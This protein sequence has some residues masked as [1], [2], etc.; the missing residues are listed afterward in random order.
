MNQSQVPQGNCCCSPQIA[1]ART[2]KFPDGTQVAIIGLDEAMEALYREGTTPG[3]STGTAILSALSY[4]NYFPVSHRA[5]YEAVFSREY[6]RFFAIKSRKS[7]G[8]K[9]NMADSKAQPGEKK[10]GLIFRLLKPGTGSKSS[11]CNVKIVPKEDP[12]A[13]KKKTSCCDVKIV[14]AEK[15]TDS[16]K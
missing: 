5:E 9:E 11:C 12:P 3:P 13:Q 10:T 2:V 8:G 14:P 7:A 4:R 6:E 15:T 1:G 16:K